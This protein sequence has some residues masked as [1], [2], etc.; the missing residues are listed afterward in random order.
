VA[1]VGDT[2]AGGGGEI[3][4]ERKFA[5]GRRTYRERSS[6]ALH[7]CGMPR[8]FSLFRASLFALLEM[9]VLKDAYA[10]DAFHLSGNAQIAMIPANHQAE[11]VTMAIPKSN[12]L[13]HKKIEPFRKCQYSDTFFKRGQEILVG[14]TF[15][16]LTRTQYGGRKKIRAEGIKDLDTR[17]ISYAK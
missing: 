8:A 14:I 11:P 15:G 16:D 3:S 1:E 6:H 9:I 2:I 7:R 5:E 4:A 12:A 10:I 13:T 17:D